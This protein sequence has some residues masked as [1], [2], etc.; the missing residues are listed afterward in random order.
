MSLSELQYRAMQRQRIVV[1]LGWFA[2]G[3][4]VGGLIGAWLA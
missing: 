4:I 2:T 1:T 3:V